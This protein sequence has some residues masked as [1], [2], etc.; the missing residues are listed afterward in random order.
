MAVEVG[1]EHVDSNVLFKN[2]DT[3]AI[4][5]RFG[6]PVWAASVER[7]RQMLLASSRPLLVA[8]FRD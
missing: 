6:D 4:I 2:K 8:G 5:L 1:I 7:R 3:S